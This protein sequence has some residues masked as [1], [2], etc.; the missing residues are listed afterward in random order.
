G[1]K[2]L[3]RWQVARDQQPQQEDEDAAEQ[4]EDR[5]DAE[6]PAIVDA[7]IPAAK[8]SDLALDPHFDAGN[9]TLGHSEAGLARFEGE[10]S[11]WFCLASSAA[12]ASAHL[13]SAP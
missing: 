1:P 5:E 3:D 10:G 9:C 13:A 11:G 2:R 12:C 4:S 6:P 7:P 8:T